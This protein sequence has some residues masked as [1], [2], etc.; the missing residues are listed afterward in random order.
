MSGGASACQQH[1]V[2]RPLP[3]NVL[4]SLEAI[5]MTKASDVSLSHARQYASNLSKQDQTIFVSRSQQLTSFGKGVHVEL[6][7]NS[8]KLSVSDDKLMAIAQRVLGKRVLTKADLTNC[9]WND[10]TLQPFT[11]KG[12][13][14]AILQNKSWREDVHENCLHQAAFRPSFAHGDSVTTEEV[15]VLSNLQEKPILAICE[16]D[17]QF[18]GIRFVEE[19]VLSFGAMMQYKIKMRTRRMVGADSYTWHDLTVGMPD[20]M[21]WL[22][23]QDKIALKWNVKKIEKCNS[24]LIGKNREIIYEMMEYHLPGNPNATP[25]S[26]PQRTVV[27]ASVKPGKRALTEHAEHETTPQTTKKR[28]PLTFMSDP[29]DKNMPSL[30]ITCHEV[31]CR[32]TIHDENSQKDI[33]DA[34]G[35]DAQTLQSDK[36]CEPVPSVYFPLSQKTQ[37]SKLRFT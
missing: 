19:M 12:T 13:I 17:L 28:K 30:D 18:G 11:E 22:I 6:H 8:L 24:T 37:V 4:T 23:V 21:S 20:K 33:G 26:S 29:R 16:D 1:D 35:V 15:I 5:I 14:T 27:I 25:D 32:E 36:L 2:P 10:P 34:Q 31:M 9:V 3:M 7:L